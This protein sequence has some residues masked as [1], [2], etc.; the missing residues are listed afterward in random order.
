M[1]FLKQKQFSLCNFVL[2]VQLEKD[3]ILAID[4]MMVTKKIGRD[5]SY[6][7][8]IKQ[9]TKHRVYKSFFQ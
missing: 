6:I 1:I 4:H 2:L 9:K 7:L 3:V 5:H 8:W